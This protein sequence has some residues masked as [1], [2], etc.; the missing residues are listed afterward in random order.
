MS[1]FIEP[2][3]PKGFR[4]LFGEDI[5]LR[6]AMLDKIR[7]VYELYGFEPLETPAME[8]VETLGKFLP[9]TDTPEGGIFALQDDANEWIALRYEFTTPLSRIIAQYPELPLPFRRYQLGPV[10]RVEK[11]KPGSFR[12]FIQFDIDTVG[13]ESMAADAEICS[14]LAEAM[15]KIGIQR[16]NYIVKVNNRKILNGVLETA[17]IKIFL[18]ESNL[19]QLA[20]QTLRTIDKL[21]RIG[22]SGIEDL[23]TT[24][25]LD[26]SGD[27]MKGV[28][29][30][31]EQV[32]III[33][34]LNITSKSRKDFCEK[35][36]SVIGN[37]R[38]GLDGIQELEDIDRYLS[39][40]GIDEHR[41]I[42][43]PTI[44]RGLT[45][46]TGPIYEVFLTFDITD[47]NGNKKQFGSVAGGGRYDDLVQRFLGK[48]VPATG[49]SIGVDRLLVALKLLNKAQVQSA[50][51]PVLVTTIDK[52]LMLEYQKITA[53][54]RNAGIS[55][56]MYLGQGGF[57]KQLKYAD[58]KNIYIAVILGSDE[59]EN[60]QITIKDLKLGEK[61]SKQIEDRDKWRKEQ[62]AQIIIPRHNLVN[63]IRKIIDKS[64]LSQ[65]K[66]K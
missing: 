64:G 16:E 56:E 65:I 44:V 61:L 2:K 22:I 5:K 32:K 62:P 59:F 12:E 17:G 21:D 30:N 54:L 10:W 24:G 31:S 43:D 3:R 20:L 9:E 29:L 37:S 26:E 51:P 57:K 47:E 25:R 55:A 23:L 1:K 40:I 36:K 33:D 41:V 52:N 6:N 28:G 66:Y 45:Y 58:K 38:I 19:T 11:P 42:F 18:D 34:Y 35:L 63:E 8:Y 7:A 39:V 27:F 13:T 49:A 46:Y 48:K 60:N 15:E 4:D 53:E 14:V 50:F